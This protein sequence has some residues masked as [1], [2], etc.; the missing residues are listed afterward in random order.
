MAGRWLS[1]GEEGINTHALAS[2]SLISAASGRTVH[3][4][5]GLLVRAAQVDVQSFKRDKRQQIDQLYGY[6]IT[7]LLWSVAVM[8][9]PKDSTRRFNFFQ[10]NQT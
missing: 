3:K 1:R 4:P 5:I 2:T 9:L 7:G 10:K 8:R 6:S